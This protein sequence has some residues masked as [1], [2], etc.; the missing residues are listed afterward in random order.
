MSCTEEEITYLRAQR[1]A[2]IAT[3]H[4][5]GQPDVVP[6]RYQFDGQYIDDLVSVDPWTP[7]YLRISLARRVRSDPVIHA[8]HAHR[9]VELEQGHPP[10]R[11]PPTCR[12]TGRIGGP[13]LGLSGA[14][15]LQRGGVHNGR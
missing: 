5:D 8:D 12:R 10:A 7:R 15:P 11:H 13:P 6:V 3:V 9:F 14:S 4:P 2:R 1:L